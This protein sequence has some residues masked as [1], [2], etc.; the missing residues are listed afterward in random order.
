MNLEALFS[1]EHSY[2]G[3]WLTQFKYPWE[4]LPRIPQ[5]LGHLVSLLP[6]DYVEIK[7]SIWVGRGT[8]I[9]EKALIQGPAIIGRRCR[10]RHNAYIRNNVLLGNEVVVGNA[11]EI[12]NAIL[13]DE[14]Q[15]PHYNYVG[16]SILGR[17]AHLGAGAILSN[18]KSTGDE[19]HVNWEGEKIGSGLTKFGALL[20]DR[21]EVGC[22]AVLYPGTIVGPDSIIY[23]LQGVRGTLRPRQI[24]KGDGTVVQRIVPDP[25]K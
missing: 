20:G 16:D 12:K 7:P 17:G 15:V 13:F 10:I 18:F 8:L 9:E 14:A 23:P 5:L 6:D 4:A 22:N 2:A 21:V 24:V 19:I 11:T 1:L 3:K 25:R